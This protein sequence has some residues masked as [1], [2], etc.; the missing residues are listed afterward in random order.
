MICKSNNAEITL[1]SV[2]RQTVVCRS[3][4]FG[5]LSKGKHLIR[6]V[7]Y[8]ILTEICF[9]RFLIPHTTN[10]LRISVQHITSTNSAVYCITFVCR[11]ASWSQI[12]KQRSWYREPQD[13][14]LKT[15]VTLRH[16][17]YGTKYAA[18]RFGW[19]VPHNTQS[20]ALREICQAI[21]D[22]YLS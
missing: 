10:R 8:L 13:P 11:T 5:C 14:G 19:R 18:M 3:L 15:A 16:T 7:Q 9:V 17:A 4:T 2:F 20:L 6:I 1:W 22:E 12:T 21:I